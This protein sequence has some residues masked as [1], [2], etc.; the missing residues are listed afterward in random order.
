M[1]WLLDFKVVVSVLG[2]EEF[3]VDGDVDE[4]VDVDLDELDEDDD[5]V[6]LLGKSVERL[7]WF[8]GEDVRKMSSV[9]FRVS[10]VV[11]RMDESFMV[12]GGGG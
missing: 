1:V 6:V 11:K 4:G 7:E 12:G 10:D 3:V 9:L 8:C 5:E 2:D